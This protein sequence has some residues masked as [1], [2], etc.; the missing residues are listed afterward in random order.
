MCSSLTTFKTCEAV[1]ERVCRN[2]CPFVLVYLKLVG[3]HSFVNSGCTHAENPQNEGIYNHYHH[4]HHCHYYH[5]NPSTTPSFTTTTTTTAT[6]S[7]ATLTTTISNMTSS[8]TTAP[9]T[10]LATITP[11]RLHSIDLLYVGRRR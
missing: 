9:F 2:S 3:I 11:A 4:S 10:T 1:W 5:L 7:T 6:L 8:F